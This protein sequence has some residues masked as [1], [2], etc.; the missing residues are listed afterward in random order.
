MMKIFFFLTINCSLLTINCFAQLVQQEWVARYTGPG[1]DLFGPFLALDKYGNSYVAGTHVI[2]DSINILCVKY[3]TSGI[4][5]WAA[6][7]KYPGEGYFAPS[8]LALD[9]S[10][11]AYVISDFGP[12]FTSPL[13]GLIVKLNS[14]NGSPVWAKRYIGQYGWSAFRDIKIDRLN[15]IYVAGWSDT[16]HLV[17]RY[18]TNGD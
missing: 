17:I 4:Q 12:G 16:S 2:N 9:S 7:Y 1:N 5:Q 11:N 6:L 13:N 14:L 8:G 3:N 10:G 18:N 15:N